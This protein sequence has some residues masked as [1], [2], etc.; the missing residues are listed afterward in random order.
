MEVVVATL[1]DSGVVR[2]WLKEGLVFSIRGFFQH[3]GGR[4]HVVLHAYDVGTREVTESTY[5]TSMSDGSFWRFCVKRS[6]GTYHKGYSYYSS[7]FMDMDLQVFV[8]AQV[9][10]I[11]HPTLTAEP[12]CPP[13]D[14]A[15]GTRTRIGR[16]DIAPLSRFNPPPHICAHVFWTLVD[17][18]FPNAVDLLQNYP[19]CLQRLLEIERQ[20]EAAQRDVEMKALKILVNSMREH[21]VLRRMK[22][23]ES[24]THFFTRVF[25]AFNDCLPLVF[26]K[27]GGSKHTAT[28]SIRDPTNPSRTIVLDVYTYTLRDLLGYDSTY[29]CHVLFYENPITPGERLSSILHI[30]PENATLTRYG[31]TDRYCSTGPY[32]AKIFDYVEQVPITHIPGTK[33]VGDVYRFVGIMVKFDFFKMRDALFRRPPAQ[34]PPPPG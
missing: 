14:H 23:G 30:E 19:A 33:G 6:D 2:G 34:F 8:D 26:R 7:T 27:E 18:V 10:A 28:K 21:D 32:T 13:F 5:Y 16:E 3:P 24:R 9:Q 22:T 29:R 31:F 4:R 12:Q 15:V 20:I 1:T 17:T 25:E 11:G